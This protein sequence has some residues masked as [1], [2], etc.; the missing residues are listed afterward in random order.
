M[1]GTNLFHLRK[2]GGRLKPLSTCLLDIQRNIGGSRRHPGIILLQTRDEFD[3]DIHFLSCFIEFCLDL[4]W[5][6]LISENFVKILEFMS[7]IG[8]QQGYQSE[9]IPDGIDD[10]FTKLA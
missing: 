5:E 10:K 8:I 7:S 6:I 3:S 9:L 4:K 1:M 2:K